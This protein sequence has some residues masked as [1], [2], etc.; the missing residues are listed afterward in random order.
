MTFE[1]W[2]EIG[3]VVVDGLRRRAVAVARDDAADPPLVRVRLV[4]DIGFA[5]VRVQGRK[6][7]SPEAREVELPQASFEAD[8]SS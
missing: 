7:K 1:A 8:A 2:A 5:D 4:E 3:T 6:I